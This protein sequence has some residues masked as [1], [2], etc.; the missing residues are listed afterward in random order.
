[1]HHHRQGAPGLGH[2]LQGVQHF[3]ITVDDMAKSIEVYTEVLGG[4]IAL[5]GDSFY[6]E[7]LHNTL[8][9]KEQ[10]EALEKGLNPR[11]P[12]VRDLKTGQKEVLDVCFI[13]FRNTVLELL[14]FHEASPGP[15][16]PDHIEKLP[17][18]I[19]FSNAAHISLHVK[20][21][22]TLNAFAVILEQECDRRDIEVAC[23]LV[24][25]VR[26]EAERAKASVGSP[27]RQQVLE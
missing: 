26:P 7:A 22:V 25:S 18:V 20:D 1:M 17:G 11:R 13:L 21:D 9:Q 2:D 10:I 23:N 16:A 5:R 6:G 8:F 3:G 14:H 4:R 12:G 24:I 15:K 27:R 19:G